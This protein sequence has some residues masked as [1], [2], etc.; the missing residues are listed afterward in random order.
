[1]QQESGPVYRYCG[2]ALAHHALGNTAESDA[3]LAQLKTLDRNDSAYQV[4]QIHAYRGE[5]DV[6]LDP[7]L[8]NLH[9]DPRWAGFLA[10]RRSSG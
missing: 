1:M 9:A 2:L 10:S 5:L 8:R 3:A 4:A 7:L 6:A